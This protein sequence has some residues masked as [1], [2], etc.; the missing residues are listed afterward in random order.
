MLSTSTG[1]S[2]SSALRRASTSCFASAQHFARHDV[3]G[4]KSKHFVPHFLRLINK[5]FRRR[6]GDEHPVIHE[7]FSSVEFFLTEDIRDGLMIFSSLC[8][9]LKL[10]LLFFG[11]RKFWMSEEPCAGFLK[12]VSEDK[13]CIQSIYSS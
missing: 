2:T 12:N 6:A 9:N 1:L 7:K 8:K 13:F 4:A 11:E 5:H 3:R 10:L